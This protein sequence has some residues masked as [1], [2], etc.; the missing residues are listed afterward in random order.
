MDREISQIFGGDGPFMETENYSPRVPQIRLAYEIKQTIQKGGVLIAEAGTGTG[1]SYAA[2]VPSILS[3]ERVVV[4]TASIA[5]QEQYLKDIPNLKIALNKEGYKVALLKGRGNFLCND[6]ISDERTVV[7]LTRNQIKAIEDLRE[8]GDRSE[9]T[10]AIS[11]QEWSKISATDEDN[12]PGKGCPYYEDCYYY[13]QREK[14]IKANL[15][16]VNYHILLVDKL[17]MG[18]DMLGQFKVL[19]ADEAHRVPDIARDFFEKTISPRTI[20][21][22]MFKARKIRSGFEPRKMS[23]LLSTFVKQQ[24]RLIGAETNV[25]LLAKQFEGFSEPLDIAEY[26]YQSAKDELEE[27]YGKEKMVLKTISTKLNN[28]IKSLKL[29][30]NQEE[31]QYVR[32]IV[33]DQSRTIKLR[34][35]DVDEP[36]SALFGEIP[37]SILMSATMRTSEG[38]G[39]IK[40]EIGLVNA[41]TFALPNI[42]NFDK[43]V[44]FY[45][46]DP[47]EMPDPSDQTKRK[48]YI[49][50]TIDKISEIVNLTGGRTMALFTSVQALNQ[51]KE[52]LTARFPRLNIYTQGDLA[53]QRLAEQFKADKQGV[54]LG[55][56]TFF[57]GIDIPGEALSC[58]ILDRFPFQP[59][60]DPMVQARQ[61]KNPSGFYKQWYLPAALIIFKQAFGR[62]IRRKTD[63]GVFIILDPR[64]R[65]KYHKSIS[66]TI[67]SDL[68]IVEWSDIKTALGNICASV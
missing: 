33:P 58:V 17:F 25:P 45:A 18:G 43:Q 46:V 38:F 55:T 53:S 60:G 49:Q 14:A 64:V 37:S 26:L 12:C 66:Q 67:Q 59:I 9:L 42:F 56:R 62:L 11:D 51:A 40:R 61:Q 32:W 41:K 5:L 50:A 6:A 4:A 13:K 10:G 24:Q 65:N 22:I 35:L 63:H 44:K 3:G 27:S 34:M 23:E 7:Q 30:I 28:I 16:I 54:L 52:N 48:E 39:L 21:Q 2:L 19:I 36:L 15:I 47:T 1:K 29:L 68:T 57:E 20:E 31:A 8:T